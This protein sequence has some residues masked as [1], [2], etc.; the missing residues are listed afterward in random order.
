M[1]ALFISLG[2]ML[3]SNAGLAIVAAF[4]WGIL[5]VLLSPCHLGS[6]PLVIGFIGGQGNM[7]T[8]RAFSLSTLFALGILVSIALIGVITAAL[9]RMLGD[10]GIWANYL[11]AGVFFLVGLY[12][13]D[14]LPLFSPGAVNVRLQ[15][16]GALASIMLGLIYGIA[17]GPCSFAFMAP[18]LALT[19]N[20]SATN[21]LFGAALL[22][23]YGVG[24]CAVIAIAGGSVELVQMFI[25][26][27]EESRGV[28][29]FRRI[30]AV[31]IIWFGIY[32]ILKA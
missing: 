28:V 15:R 12:L 20:S 32:L 9:G 14:L 1:E 19:F 30:C 11:A 24:H 21:P 8:R 23:I 3:E 22:A 25:N 13:L 2:G 26:W 6:I 27:G 7:T 16:K 29:W 18:I 10:I 31:L 5:S 4:V 17:L